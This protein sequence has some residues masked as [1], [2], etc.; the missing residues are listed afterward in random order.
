MHPPGTR[1][2]ENRELGRYLQDLATVTALPAVWGSGDG[3]RIADG[4]AEVAV[5][6][7]HLD[8][9]YVRLEGSTAAEKVEALHFAQS[10]TTPLSPAEVGT[11]LAPSTGGREN[12]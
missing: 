8:F 7:L 4:M 12:E 9:A 6:I 2:P 3:R 10:P 5:S 1:P 11:T